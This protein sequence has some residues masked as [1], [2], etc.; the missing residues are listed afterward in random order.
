MLASNPKIKIE[1]VVTDQQVEQVIDI[2][3][4]AARTNK[5]G[6]GKIFVYPVES[7]IRVRTGETGDAAI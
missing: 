2:I 6:D 3:A 4:Q 5:V 7:A 1:I